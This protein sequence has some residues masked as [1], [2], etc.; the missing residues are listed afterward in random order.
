MR[1][2]GFFLGLGSR[3]QSMQNTAQEVPGTCHLQHIKD[4]NR[5]KQGAFALLN[6]HN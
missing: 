3:V 4:L 6:L 2:G 1:G 5:L